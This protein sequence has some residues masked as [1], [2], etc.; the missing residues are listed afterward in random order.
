MVVWWAY[1]MYANAGLTAVAPAESGNGN[2]K[3]YMP[4]DDHLRMPAIK[5]RYNTFQH[6][7]GLLSSPIGP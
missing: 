3:L 2:E 5:M 6:I 7:I 1:C 4:P